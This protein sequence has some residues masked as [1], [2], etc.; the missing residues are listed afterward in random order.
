MIVGVVLVFL[1]TFLKLPLRSKLL[2]EIK[3]QLRFS[4]L[5][6]FRGKRFQKN[7]F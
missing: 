7:L 2:F 4:V 3:T 5:I 6:K 1:I